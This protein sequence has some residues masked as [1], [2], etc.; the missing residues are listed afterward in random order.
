MDLAKALEEV[1]RL[2]NHAPDPESGWHELVALLAH[3]VCE[4]AL[5]PLKGAAIASDVANVREQIRALLVS[6]PPPSS[7]RALY[8]GLFDAENRDGVQSIGYYISGVDKYDADD[9]DS[10]CDSV[11]WP[12]GRYLTS[13]AL[14]AINRAESSAKEEEREVLGYTGQ[15]GAALLVSRFASRGLLEGVRRVVGFDSGDVGEVLD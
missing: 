4:A 3:H 8:F 2:A 13:A 5:A 14:D 12:K 15:L 10:L 1:A 6:E 9:L 7:L 11:W